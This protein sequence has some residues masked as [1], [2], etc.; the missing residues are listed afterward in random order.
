[1]SMRDL[2]RRPVDDH[3]PALAAPLGRELRYPV[4]RQLEI[5]VR[6]A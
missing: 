1:L 6:S 5:V 4:D 2:A 3:Q